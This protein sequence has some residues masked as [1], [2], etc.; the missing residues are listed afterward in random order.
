[1][2]KPFVRGKDAK[3]RIF[4][5]DTEVVVRVKNWNVKR[6][7]TIIADD[8]NGEERSQLDSVTNFYSMSIDVF[9]EDG[10][11]LDALMNIQDAKDSSVTPDD[12]AALFTLRILDG[13]KRAFTMEAIELDDWDFKSSSRTDALMLTIPLRGQYF[14]AT[15]TA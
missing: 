14:R 4:K 15:K 3:F 6:N 12:V 9:T 8:V 11:V 2:G 5:G 13:S 7:A 1:M 10:K